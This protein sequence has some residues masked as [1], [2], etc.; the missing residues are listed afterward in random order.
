MRA[1][2]RSACARAR[3]AHAA[4]DLTGKRAAEPAHERV[5]AAA[6]HRGVQIDH[7][8]QRKSGES[9]DPSVEIVRLEHEPLALLEL[10]DAAVHEID[11]GNQHRQDTRRTGMPCAASARFRSRT[12]VSA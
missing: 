12:D 11:R 5:V 1:A 8:H 2:S 9:R 6:A 7:L 4:A 10:D 3:R